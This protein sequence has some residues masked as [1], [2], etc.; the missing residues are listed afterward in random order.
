MT[1]SSATT[2]QVNVRVS[3][4]VKQGAEAQLQRM[5]SSVGTLVR[6]TLEKA[7]RSAADCA[8]VV[9]LVSG[10]GD[11]RASARKD[12]LLRGWEAADGFCGSLGLEPGTA[13]DDSRTWD[14]TYRQAMDAHF[15]EKGLFE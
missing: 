9:A 15:A 10:A 11:E 13:E 14:E 1:A 6:Q 5:D 12:A 2:V 7:S 8:E 4:G 3:P